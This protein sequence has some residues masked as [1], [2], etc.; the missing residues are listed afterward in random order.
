MPIIF[1]PS[2]YSNTV[3][4][5]YISPSSSSL[6]YSGRRSSYIVCDSIPNDTIKINPIQMF[7]CIVGKQV[8]GVK[9]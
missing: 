3:W 1:E 6:Y 9:I 7:S 4:V 5:N 2:I 8:N